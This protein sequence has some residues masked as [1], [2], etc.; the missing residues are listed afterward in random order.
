MQELLH[1]YWVGIFHLPSM[2]SSLLTLKC[3]SQC[4]YTLVV[5]RISMSSAQTFHIFYIYVYIL[6]MQKEKKNAVDDSME[7]CS[8]L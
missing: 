3:L 5:P 1:I 2:I 4:I 6:Q 7:Y 8:Y